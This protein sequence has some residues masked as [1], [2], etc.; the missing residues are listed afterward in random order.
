MAVNFKLF[1]I[2]FSF[3]TICQAQSELCISS[4]D[5]PVILSY[6]QMHVHT[7]TADEVCIVLAKTCNVW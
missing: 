3:I 1:C 7:Y 2:L 5:I 6:Y 4:A